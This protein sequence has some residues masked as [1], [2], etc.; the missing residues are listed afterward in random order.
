MLDDTMT[1]SP[2][3]YFPPLSDDLNFPVIERSIGWHSGKT[4]NWYPTVGHK[5]LL[6]TRGV[7]I[8]QKLAIVGDNYQVVNNND[9]FPYIEE[10]MTRV[11][12][13]QQL[14]GVLTSEKSAYF[15]RDCYR[16]YVFPNMKCDIRGGN[17]AFRLI[18]GNSYGAKAVTLMCG[19]IDF[20]CSNGMIFG[21]HEKTAR[22]HTS[23]IT[24]AG[25]EKWIKQA[26]AQFVSQGTR[27]EKL[28]TLSMSVNV[29]EQ[30]K[31]L[32]TDTSLL[33][34]RH[35]EQI[36]AATQD[37]AGKRQG[38]RVFPTAWHMYSALTDWASH[39]N[40]RDTGNDHEAS[41]R[42]ERSRHVERVMHA[43]EGFLVN[44]A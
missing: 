34:A 33:S 31:T 26:Q 3:H 36:M 32:L 4:D 16:E 6:R 40:V 27:L 38:T 41:T 43:V 39:G 22:K 28:E 21:S 19:A 44:A 10:Y 11:M 12:T 18:V 8:P 42:I 37:E 29:M 1:L 17:V 23:G 2:R 20:W 13:P 25:L 5:M 15:G 24:L 35:A 30:I 14:D 9:L 7:Q